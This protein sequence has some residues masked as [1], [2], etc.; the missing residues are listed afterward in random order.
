MDK[1]VYMKN[2]KISKYK[3]SNCKYEDYIK[4]GSSTY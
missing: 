2:I 3:I 1:N 4:M